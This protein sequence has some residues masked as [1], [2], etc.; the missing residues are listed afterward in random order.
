MKEKNAFRQKLIRQRLRVFENRVLRKI[1]GSKEEV[2]G[3]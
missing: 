3:G 2:T 1:V